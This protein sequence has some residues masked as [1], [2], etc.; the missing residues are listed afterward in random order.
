[1]STK[2][3]PL[4]KATFCIQHGDEVIQSPEYNTN[5]NEAGTLKQLRQTMHRAV[6]E[7]FNTLAKS[8]GVADEQSNPEHP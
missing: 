3:E 5:P 8:V 2:A 1:M 6:D 4:V 7:A